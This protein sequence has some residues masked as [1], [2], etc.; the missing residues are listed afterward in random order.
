MRSAKHKEKGK[1]TAKVK[2]NTPSSRSTLKVK[3]KE[4]AE[5]E[6]EAKREKAQEGMEKVKERPGL[7]PAI[8]L[9]S[10]EPRARLRRQK[11]RKTKKKL[12]MIG[13]K[14]WT[15][16]ISNHPSRIEKKEG[17][18]KK[19]KVERDL[20]HLYLF[21]LLPGQVPRGDHERMKGRWVTSFFFCLN[22]ELKTQEK[23]RK[24]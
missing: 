11:K 14:K 5:A 10:F 7:N 6:A 22:F 24:N 13:R 8:S 1:A 15:Q 2:E 4:R 19:N 16:I 20:E 17:G 21:F 12:R 9:R 3:E 23:F 18:S